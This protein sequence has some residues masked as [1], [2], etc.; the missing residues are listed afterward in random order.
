MIGLDFDGVVLDVP[1]L[2]KILGKKIMLEEEFW[3]IPVKLLH[4]VKG[5]DK[6]FATGKVGAVVTRRKEH[7]YVVR[8]FKFWF[9][10]VLSPIVCVGWFGDKV[11][12]CKK[13]RISVFIDDDY[14]TVKALE[15]EGISAFWFRADRDGDLYDCLVRWRV[16]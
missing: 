9:G 12:W 16:L 13:L 7:L 10:K 4:P 15:Q 6:V 11:L 5:V 3:R 14:S 2:E 1:R 8:W